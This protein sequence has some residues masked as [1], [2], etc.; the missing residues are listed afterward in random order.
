MR[1]LVLGAA[2]SFAM[3]GC[4]RFPGS[5][6]AAGYT[7]LHLTITF[8]APVD[9]HYV[10]AVAIRRITSSTETNDRLG[11]IPVADAGSKNGVVEGQ[12][13]HLVV[14]NR[15]SPQFFTV[16]AFATRTPTEIDP[17]PIELASRIPIGEAVVGVDPEAGAAG[18]VQERQLEFEI[19]AQDLATNADGS[20]IDP[21]TIHF[22]QF[23]I[24]SMNKPALNSIADRVMDALGDS[25]S[26][27]TISFGKY[28]QVPIDTGGH[29]T[30]SL[31]DRE[32]AGDTYHGTLPPVD[33]TD[34]SLDVRTP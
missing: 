12:P 22:I 14:Y 23:N 6:A 16:N 26:T 3:L 31:A 19:S 34:W 20:M 24:L 2:A 28:R 13:T 1:W 17:N 18:S 21:T 8:A 9:D 32:E 7:R 27:G 25:R 11:P 5:G 30:D 15:L 33:I 10:Y 29:L 4:A